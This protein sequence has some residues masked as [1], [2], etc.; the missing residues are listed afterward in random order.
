MSWEG[1][2]PTGA[3]PTAL[4]RGLH[5][6]EHVSGVRCDMQQVSSVMRD[7][8]PCNLNHSPKRPHPLVLERCTRHK[9]MQPSRS[10]IPTRG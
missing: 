3:H 4:C 10:S 1:R 5:V 7:L 8:I 9:K 6:A 2:T